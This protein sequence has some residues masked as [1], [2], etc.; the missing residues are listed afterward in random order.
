[1]S[2]RESVPCS[3]VWPVSHRPRPTCVISACKYPPCTHVPYLLPRGM[4]ALSGE[5]HMANARCS[6]PRSGH[7]VRSFAGFMENPVEHVF[8]GRKSRSL[9]AVKPRDTRICFASRCLCLWSD[10]ANVTAHPAPPMPNIPPCID[11]DSHSAGPIA[12]PANG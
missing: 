4:A 11:F 1:M 3:A 9:H 2:A 10:S 8:P 5:R 12:L 7:V 6:K